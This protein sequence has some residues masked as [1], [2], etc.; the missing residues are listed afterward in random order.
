MLNATERFRRAER[1]AQTAKR[2]GEPSLSRYARG[3]LGID[4]D[5]CERLNRALRRAW[6]MDPE[7]RT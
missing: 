4:L 3:V 2:R 6:N 1:I 7:I 5:K